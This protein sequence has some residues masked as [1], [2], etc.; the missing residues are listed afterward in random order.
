MQRGYISWMV[1]RHRTNNRSIQ[2][3][4]SNLSTFN[5]KRCAGLCDCRPLWL[6]S[7]PFATHFIQVYHRGSGQASLASIMHLLMV[8]PRLYF[9]CVSEGLLHAVGIGF[10]P[11]SQNN[12]SVWMQVKNT[13]LPF[14]SSKTTSGKCEVCFSGETFLCLLLVSSTLRS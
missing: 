12:I 9:L 2:N 13:V 1:F 6:M 8:P 5:W 7:V 14:V 11:L 10:E 4:V 3:N